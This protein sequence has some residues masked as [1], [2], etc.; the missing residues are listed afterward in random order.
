M[1]LNGKL[2]NKQ[3]KI[4]VIYNKAAISNQWEKINCSIDVK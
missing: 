1:K 2:I 3:I 4:N